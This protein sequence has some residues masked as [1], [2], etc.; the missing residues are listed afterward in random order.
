MHHIPCCGQLCY[1]TATKLLSRFRWRW[2]IVRPLTIALVQV[3]D[4]FATC[5]LIATGDNKNIETN[6]TVEI[7]KLHP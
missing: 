5:N 2:V 1:Q 4:F 6:A 7:C 3:G